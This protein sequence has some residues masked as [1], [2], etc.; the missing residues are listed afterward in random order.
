MKLFSEKVAPTFTN[1]DYNTPTFT[2]SNYN[3]LILNEYTEIFFDVYELEIN[4][5]KYIAEKVSEY[6]GNPVVTIPVIFEGEELETLFVLRRGELEVIINSFYCKLNKDSS[7]DV[8]QMHESLSREEEVESIIFEKKESILKEI[9]Q[10]RELA[11]RFAEDIKQQKI[12]ESLE[13][14]NKEKEAVTNKIAE[15]KSELIDDFLHIVENTRQEFYTY[16]EEE[17]KQTSEL[18]S[19]TLNRLSEKLESSIV[20]DITEKN[21]KSVALFK[22]K[23]SELAES[24]L[25]ESLIKEIERRDNINNRVIE[26]KVEAVSKL[27]S[28]TLSEQI[29]DT[30]VD[31]IGR[32]SLAEDKIKDYYDERITLIEGNIT[33]ISA[34][35]KKHFI[36]LI[37]ES[38]QS[39][40]DEVSQIKTTVPSVVI[41]KTRETKG[42]VDVKLIKTDL[43]KTISNRFTQELANVRRLIEMS[44]GGGSVAVQFANGGTMRG[45]LNVI[46]DIS[47]TGV[48]YNNNFN[49]NNWNDTYT[50]VSTTSANWDTVYTTVKANSANWDNTYTSVQANSANWDTG[51]NTATALNLSSGLWNDTYTTVSTTSGNWNSAYNIAS[52]YQ[53]AS[54]TFATIDYTSNNFFPLSGGTISG[55]TKVRFGDLTVYGNI[56]A[57]GSINYSNT[58]ISTTSSLCAIA[59]STYPIPG[60]YVGQTG[61]GD[62]ASFYDLSPTMRE[63]FHIGGSEGY[64]GVGVNTSFPNKD[65]TV[66]GDI[67]ATGIIYNNNFNST[68]WNGTYTTVQT[69]SATNWNYQGSDLKALSGNWQSTYTNLSTYYPL[70][71][72]TLNGSI[73]ATG[74]IATAGVITASGSNVNINVITVNNSRVF[75]DADN[76]KV[77]HLDTTTAS[78]CAIFPSTL[79]SGFNVAI[80]NIGV[81]SLVLSAT[82]LNS[83]GTIITTKFGG[84]FVYKDSTN[85]F[86]VGRLV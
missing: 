50:S 49:S 46:G 72:G 76:N 63:V 6:K 51:Y 80:M 52:T 53:T 13:Y 70:T 86:A 58:F 64:P 81:N 36:K 27:L 5:N 75:T 71:G 14:I 35:N 41:E 48:I 66:V 43:E 61:S 82:Q 31:L 57:T 54:S 19:K 29:T 73:S 56:S 37:E 68:D 60:L 85:L 26:A 2:G 62:I 15:L 10:T 65:F 40:L 20:R 11:T 23:I 47:A 77:V 32:I 28:E 38:K 84:A 79:S 67:S 33:D 7:L 9:Q 8:P 3:I 59:N 16:N 69:N 12:Q 21:N 1:P 39:I 44:S 83:A 30:T 78:L 22:Q 18:I 4:G 74:N 25:N 24:I 34:E 55:D 17:K 42:D 45:N